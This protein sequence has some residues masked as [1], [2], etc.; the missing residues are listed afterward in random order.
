VVLRVVL[1]HAGRT[2]EWSAIETAVA[3]AL[4]EVEC[5]RTLDRM[6][7]D[8]SLDPS[9]IAAR[10]EAIY[11]IMESAEVVEPTGAVL[12]RA[13]SPMPTPLGTLD[14][15][16]LATALLWSDARGQSPVMLTHDRALANASRAFGLTVVGV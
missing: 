8:G 4:V 13:S 6:A 14:A 16:H 15:I 2:R 5:L 10:R 11:R 7:L 1:Q 3:S 12:K 9:R